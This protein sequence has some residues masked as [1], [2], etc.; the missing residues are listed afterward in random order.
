MNIGDTKRYT[1]K[2]F[3]FDW[4]VGSHRNNSEVPLPKVSLKTET[5]K[6]FQ[7]EEVASGRFKNQEL[8]S[9]KKPK[10]GKK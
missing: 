10:A 3:S 5:V 2:N 1:F 9:G 4:G 7:W 6:G 8:Y